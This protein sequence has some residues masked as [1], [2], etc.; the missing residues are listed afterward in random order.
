MA[1]KDNKK[2]A[3]K[4]TEAE[5][6][7]QEQFVQP[8]DHEWFIVNTYSGH[9]NKVANQIEQRVKANNLE[10]R[11]SKVMVPT[12]DKI[13]VS[14]GKKRTIQEKLF[15]GYVL[16]SMDMDENTWSIIRN[17]D[18]VTGFVGSTKK[19]A[20]LSKKEVQGI[21][22]FMEADKPAF[23]ASFS[24]GDAVKVL[25]GPFKDFVGTI[26]EI[27]EDKGKARV[28]LSVFGRETPVDLEFFKVTRL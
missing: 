14:S 26:S 3:D 1:D 17:T 7:T 18:G 5:E 23:Q 16:I 15:P 8:E 19:P 27:D 22:A 24:V 4:K 13:V 11:I 6:S 21:M 9:E 10:D 12:Q 20:P 28:L 25:D 2:K